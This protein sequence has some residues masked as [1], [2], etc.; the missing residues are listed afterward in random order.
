MAD[1]P[2]TSAAASLGSTGG[3]LSSNR[4]NTSTTAFILNSRSSDSKAVIRSSAIGLNSTS[5]LAPSGSGGL[6][7][8]GSC[9]SGERCPNS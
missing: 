7:P 4:L 9:G 8:L 3:F 1:S 6:G 5:L 2:I